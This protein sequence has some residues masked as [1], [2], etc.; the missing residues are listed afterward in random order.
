M[1]I[2]TPFGFFSI[3]CAQDTKGGPHPTDMLVRARRLEH[4]NAIQKYYNLP[5]IQKDGGT[6]Y[7]YRITVPMHIV[8]DMIAKEVR[9]IH[10]TNFKD[11]AHRVGAKDK[12]Y[13]QFLHSVWE[14]GC[15]LGAMGAPRRGG[16]PWRNTWL[17]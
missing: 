11:E 12:P 3:V 9:D 7:P 15:R 8:Q 10:Y 13:H 5:A 16:H 2:M 1:W 17:K 4:I 14:L 6:D